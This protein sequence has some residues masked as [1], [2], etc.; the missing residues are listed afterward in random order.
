MTDAAIVMITKREDEIVQTLCR[1]EEVPA[2]EPL[3][4]VLPD[5]HAVAVYRWEGGFYC[6][7]DLCSHGEASLSEGFVEEGQ[8][9]CPFH[10]GS[11]CISTGEP[12]AAPCSEPIRAY[13]VTERDGVLLIER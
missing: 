11:F 5:D 7:D 6:T 2:D 1:A 3:R 9:F 8:I 4:V 13:A 12:R 10:M